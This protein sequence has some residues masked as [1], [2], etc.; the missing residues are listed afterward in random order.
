MSIID[1]I[2]SRMTIHRHMEVMAIPISRIEVVEAVV[3]VTAE[4][5]VIEAQEV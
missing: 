1:R 4:A 2:D 3:E 5:G